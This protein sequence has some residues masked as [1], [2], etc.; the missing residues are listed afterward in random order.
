LN[1]VIEGKGTVLVRKVTLMAR[2]LPH[3]VLPASQNQGVRD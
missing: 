3:R 1:L 2:P